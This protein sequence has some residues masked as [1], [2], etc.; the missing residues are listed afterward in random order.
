MGGFSL[1]LYSEILPVTL[2]TVPSVMLKLSSC[3]VRSFF[4]NTCKASPLDKLSVKNSFG[5]THFLLKNIFRLQL[6]L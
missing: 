4:K 5:K 2:T 3:S 6:L 1:N